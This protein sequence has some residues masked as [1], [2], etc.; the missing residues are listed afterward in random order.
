LKIIRIRV[1]RMM[2]IIPISEMIIRMTIMIIK[3]ND[4]NNNNN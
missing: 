3:E 1:I 4:D 2:I